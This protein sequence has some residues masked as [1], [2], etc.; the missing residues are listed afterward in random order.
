MAVS[1]QVMVLSVCVSVG[2]AGIRRRRETLTLTESAER[3][4]SQM[5]D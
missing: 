5:I 4:I 1:K 2:H 3:D